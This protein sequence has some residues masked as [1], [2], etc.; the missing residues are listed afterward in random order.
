M[1]QLDGHTLGDRLLIPSVMLRHERDRFLDD[2]TTDELTTRL[3][4]KLVTVE[5]NGANLSKKCSI[6]KGG[7]VLKRA[8]LILLSVFV[9]L[10]AS[11]A[12]AYPG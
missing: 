10:L 3:G 4:V 6:E 11:C 2:L 1:S 9:I 8:I 5:S 7:S 12:A